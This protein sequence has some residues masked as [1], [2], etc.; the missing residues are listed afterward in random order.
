MADQKTTE[1][2]KALESKRP[3]Y[4]PAQRC[5]RCGGLVSQDATHD[6][7]DLRGYRCQE[8]GG[9][10]IMPGGAASWPMTCRKMTE[11]EIRERDYRQQDAILAE[12]RKISEHLASIEDALV[13]LSEQD[14]HGSYCVCTD[15]QTRRVEDEERAGCVCG[16]CQPIERTTKPFGPASAGA[17]RISAPV[18]DEPKAR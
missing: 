16:E 9:F 12:L 11:A 3:P 4:D 1:A 18:P 15:C 7:A 2:L 13:A 17:A 10:C 14:E 5:P 8:H 6:H